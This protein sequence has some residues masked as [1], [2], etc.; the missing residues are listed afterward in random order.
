MILDDCAAFKDVKGR[1]GHLVEMA[2]SARHIGIS[3]WVLT[4]DSTSITPSFRENLAV[5]V[6]FTLLGQDHEGHL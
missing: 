4:Q 3:V 5:I 2:F 1:T 6:Y